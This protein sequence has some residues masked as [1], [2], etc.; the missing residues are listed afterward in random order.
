MNTSKSINQLICE[1][2]LAPEHRYPTL[3]HFQK[4]PQASDPEPT[5]YFSDKVE[6][7]EINIKV[8]EQ[9]NMKQTDDPDQ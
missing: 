5:M 7:D 1:K 2:T 3:F 8:T 9:W 6:L 4:H